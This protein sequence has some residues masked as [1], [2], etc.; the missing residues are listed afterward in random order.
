MSHMKS[1]AIDEQETSRTSTQL[2]TK[3]FYLE[4]RIED[5]EAR[6]TKLERK[7]MCLIGHIANLRGNTP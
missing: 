5:L 1:L 4:S 7:N 3:I 2:R 6:N